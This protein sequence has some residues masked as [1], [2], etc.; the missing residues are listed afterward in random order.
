MMLDY[1]NKEK[2]KIPESDLDENRIAEIMNTN[3]WNSFF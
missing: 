1:L 2:L 3:K